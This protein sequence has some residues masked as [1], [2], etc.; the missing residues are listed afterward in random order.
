RPVALPPPPDPSAVRPILS[1][2]IGV[3]RDRQSLEAALRALLP[4][5]SSSG[6]AGD[7]AAVGLMMAVAALGREESRGGHYR[8]DCPQT[9][10]VARRSMRT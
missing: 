6:P 5:A 1:R 3:L 4:L 9:A 2:G 7:P 8:T 10:M